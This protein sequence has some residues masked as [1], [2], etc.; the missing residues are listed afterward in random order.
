MCNADLPVG[1][2]VFTQIIWCDP[3]VL[4]CICIMQNTILIHIFSNQFLRTSYLH[5]IIVSCTMEP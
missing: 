4:F 2:T 3:G 5:A 1:I